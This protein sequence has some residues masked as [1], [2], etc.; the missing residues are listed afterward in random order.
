MTEILLRRDFGPI[1]RPCDEAGE[2]ALKRITQGNIV[3]V[4]VKQPRNVHHHRKFFALMQTIFSN[5]SHYKTLEHLLSAFKFAC[6]HTEKIRTARGEIEI[7]RSISFA[8]MD[9]A[10]FEAFYDRAV[11]FVTT[12]VI[13]GLDSADLAR[14]VEELC[15]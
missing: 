5:Q 3:A 9:Q 8:K 4:N 13:P 12:E 6:G 14:E 10:E 11:E 7:P 2:S 15:R 1:L